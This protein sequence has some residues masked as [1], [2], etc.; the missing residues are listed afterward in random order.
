MR[1]ASFVGYHDAMTHATDTGAGRGPTFTGM[2]HGT[3]SAAR[4]VGFAA[5]SQTLVTAASRSRACSSRSSRRI[6]DVPLGV[7]QAG[8]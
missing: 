5:T 4:V 2:T 3:P 7:D 6:E 8:R 1:G